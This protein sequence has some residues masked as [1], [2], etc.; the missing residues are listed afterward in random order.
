[1]RTVMTKTTTDIRR[2][3]MTDFNETLKAVLDSDGQ[4]FT[5]N[6][7]QIVSERIADRIDDL[8]KEISIDMLNDATGNRGSVNESTYTFK[9]PADVKKFIGS[10]SEVGL[11][12]KS[13]KVSGKAV[14]VNG[15]KDK[16]VLSLLNL[17]A[18]DMKADIKE[19]QDLIHNTMS[20]ILTKISRGEQ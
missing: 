12:K 5:Q 4:Q 11:D 14:T 16:E 2:V 15:V 6:I 3:S 17:V 10:A 13:M 19:N 8:K 18:K 20:E 7:H 1:M 9:S